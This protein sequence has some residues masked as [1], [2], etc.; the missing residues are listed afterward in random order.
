MTATRISRPTGSLYSKFL[1]GTLLTN[2]QT[3]EG[4]ELGS[5]RRNDVMILDFCISKIVV[6]QVTS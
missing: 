5:Q 6:Y 3:E 4:L 1:A 2:E